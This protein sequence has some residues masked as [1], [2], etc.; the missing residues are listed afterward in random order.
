VIQNHSK[1]VTGIFI[2]V[3]TFF[4][5]NAGPKDT[6]ANL[7]E[8]PRKAFTLTAP[9]L[10]YVCSFNDSIHF[11]IKPARNDY[12]PDSVQVFLAG[13]KVP[14]KIATPLAFSLKLPFSKVGRQNLRL[15][16]YYNGSLI[17]ELPTQITVLSDIEPAIL[18]YK[19]IR[20]LPHDADAY[21]Q[22]LFWYQGYLYEGTGLPRKSK[23]M[24]IDPVDGKITME[25]KMGSEFFGEGITRWKNTIYQL[26]YQEKVG[27]VYNLATFEQIREF[28]LQTMEGWGL[29]ADDQN[30]IVSD[31]SSVLY[32]Y[33]PDYFSQV[34]QLDV[35]DNKGL[36]T[37]L[38]E[39]EYAQKAIWA[40]VYG[41]PYILKIDPQTGKVLGRL[42][43]EALFPKNIPRDMD[44]VLN[45]I[46]FDPSS[47]T[48]FVTG[49]FWPVM[50][51]IRIIE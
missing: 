10:D 22:G 20:N 7:T 40:N 23:L 47:A 8:K 19:V 31:G 43:L 38:N 1:I 11:R 4:S 36:V 45:G 6:A 32:F 14:R 21:I 2:C 34:N 49:K 16:V 39:L 5:C 13:K 25:Y 51:E 33:D 29:T 42:N 18:N 48:Y 35:C 46:A 41:K 30:L 44:H 17:Q 3:V 37:L 9:K 27:F 15:V 50:Y 12:T 28:N 24:K 26:T